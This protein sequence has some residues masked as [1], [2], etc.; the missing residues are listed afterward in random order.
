MEREQEVVIDA[1]VV[2]KWF[3][4]EEGSDRAIAL[5][6]DHVEGRKTLI[7]PDL[8]I[9]EVVNALRFKPRFNPTTTVRALNDLLELR[10]DI[11]VPTR[12]VISKCSELAYKY[13]ITSYDSYYL[14]L[15]EF[16]GLEVVTADNRLYQKAKECRFLQLL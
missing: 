6:K 12:E 2:I 15:G 13:E 4:Q 16:L 5:R 11:M 10:L 1:S 9:Y 3:S 7:S 8:L 14:A